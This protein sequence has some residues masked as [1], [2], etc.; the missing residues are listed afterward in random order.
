[1]FSF[2][3]AW[4]GTVM[5]KF[6]KIKAHPYNCTSEI[7]YLYWKN[8]IGCLKVNCL[9]FRQ[10]KHKLHVLDS[11]SPLFQ[12]LLNPSL[13]IHGG[14][15]GAVTGADPGFF[16]GGGTL[17]SCSTSTPINHIVFFL[18]NTSCIRKPQVISGG[19]VRTPCTLPLDPPLSQ[20]V[21][22]WCHNQMF[23]HWCYLTPC[24]L[25]VRSIMQFVY[26]VIVLITKSDERNIQHVQKIIMINWAIKIMDL[27]L[28]L[29]I[30]FSLVIMVF[31]FAL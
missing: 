20:S 8:S 6:L 26:V 21:I 31:Y 25:L 28:S 7:Q 12:N 5:C 11:P 17:V 19:G 29:L 18:Q 23:S 14:G 4:N 9:T 30:I 3:Q 2:Y 22:C 13:P 16:L 15:G 24:G 27:S 1:M 10:D